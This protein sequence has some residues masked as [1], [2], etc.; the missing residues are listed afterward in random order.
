MKQGR[1]GN[2]SHVNDV[3]WTQG[4]HVGGEV[5]IQRTYILEFTIE[6]S[7]DSP[8]PKRSQD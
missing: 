4:G 8:D 3:W 7:N 5:H 6:R 2:I 1:P